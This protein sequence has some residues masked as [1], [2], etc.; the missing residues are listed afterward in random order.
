M[1]KDAG[2]A[3]PTGAHVH[4]RLRRRVRR[5]RSELAVLAGVVVLVGY[6]SLVPLGYLCWRTFFRDGVPTFAFFRKAYSAFDLGEMVLNSLWFAAGS[7]VLAVTVGTLLAFLVV[8]TDV[9]GR[10]AL[11]VASLVPLAVPGVLYTISWIFLAS[12]RSG[13]LNKLLEPVLGRG[14]IDVFGIW[15]MIVVEGLHL[16]PL[17]LLLMAAAFRSMDPALEEAAVV[18][19]ASPFTAFRR[20]T[21]PLV[22]P[23][24][25]ASILIMTVRALEA[26]EVPA[27]LGLPGGRWVFTSRIWRALGEYPPAYGEAGAYSVSLLVLTLVGVAAYTLVSRRGRR[28]ETISG[29]GFR[30]RSIP[31]GRWR[32]PAAG[33]VVLYVTVAAALPLLLLFYVSTQ[34]FYATPSWEGLGRMSFAQY[35]DLLSD[36]Q[37]L[38]AAKNSLVLGIGTATAVMLCMAVAAWIIVRT[39]IRGRWLVDGLAFIPLAVPGL[40]LGVGVLFFYL[41]VPLPIYGSLWILFIAYFTRFMPYGIRSTAVSVQ[42]IGRELE[43]SAYTCGASWWH[44]FRRVILPLMLPGI[45][46]G[47]IYIMLISLREL[48]TSILLYSPG[49]EVLPVVIWERYQ[50]GQLPALAALGVIMVFVTAGLAAVAFRVGSRMGVRGM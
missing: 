48:S 40:V 23:A 9:P 15:G 17:V 47:W 21:L 4:C 10:R 34:P 49:K 16:A 41:R 18:S 20:V 43:E 27:L 32:W 46:A 7:T 11:L 26:F 39:R 6:L 37:F 24:L 33:A 12:P 1:S 2:Y 8:R 31:L 19:G 22:R 5:V 45:V 44:A 35:A 42:Q 25:A 29:K 28:F 36:E 3:A 38:R 30:P 13:A 50:D 14:A